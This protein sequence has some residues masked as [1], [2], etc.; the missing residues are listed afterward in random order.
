[1]LNIHYIW[2]VLDIITLTV[3]YW[4]AITKV[5]ILTF[6]DQYFYTSFILPSTICSFWECLFIIAL[7]LSPSP[8]PRWKTTRKLIILHTLFLV[9]VKGE[10]H[11]LDKTL[12]ITI[13]STR[14]PYSKERVESILASTRNGLASVDFFYI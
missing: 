14:F 7:S 2:I 10:C 11:L 3:A 5:T 8:F 1:M 6:M 4:D 9:G 13:I 12:D